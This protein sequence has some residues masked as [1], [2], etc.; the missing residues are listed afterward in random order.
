MPGK[1]EI[2]KSFGG[3]FHLAADRRDWLVQLFKQQSDTQG[4]PQSS[5]AFHRLIW[6][7]SRQVYLYITPE[8]TRKLKLMSFVQKA[9]KHLEEI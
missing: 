2:K 8:T 6:L 4:N 9:K 1:S 5:V 3:F 7:N